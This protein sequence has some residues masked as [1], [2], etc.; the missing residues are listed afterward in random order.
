MVS[1]F[2]VNVAACWLV[3]VALLRSNRESVMREMVEECEVRVSSVALCVCE[4]S[5]DALG[6]I[7]RLPDPL[8]DA[9][10]ADQDATDAMARDR[11]A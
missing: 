11:H 5:G 10:S 6:C 1:L 2:M 3:D 4:L 8:R 9:G 7:R